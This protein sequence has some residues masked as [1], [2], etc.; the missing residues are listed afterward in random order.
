M[1][2]KDVEGCSGNKV[3]NQ[4]EDENSGK[5]AQSIDEESLPVEH[6]LHPKRRA[7][8]RFM[9]DGFCDFANTA[10]EDS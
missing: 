2:V 1:F 8:F 4:C 5:K 7:V 3:E 9:V 10:V 6:S